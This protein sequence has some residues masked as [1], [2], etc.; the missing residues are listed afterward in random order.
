MKLSDY[1]W[2]FIEQKVAD[3][4]F[5][6]S[7]GGI[8][9][10]VD[11]LGRSNLKSYCCHHEQAVAIAAEGY[12]RI[13]NSP[14]VAL[15]T[16]GPGGTNAVTG[17]AGAWLDSI[18]M[19]VVAGQVKRAD[20]TPRDANG[21]PVVRAIGF[22]E[23]NVIDIAKPVCKYAVTVENEN[24]I[25][26]HLEK[27]LYLATHGRPG[28]VFV[29]IPLDVQAAE[30]DP[31]TL[32]SFQPESWNPG[33][34]ERATME[35]IVTLLREAKRPL[36]IAGNGIRLAGGEEIL[37]KSLDKFKI[38]AVTPIFTA[39]DL[40]TYDYPYYLGRQGMPGNKAANYAA[41]NCDLLLIVGERMQLTQV[42]WDYNKFAPNAKKIMVDIDDNE[43]K[44][45]QLSVDLAVHCDAK[46]FLDELYKQDITL[47]RWDVKVEPLNPADLACDPKY[48]NVYKFWREIGACNMSFRPGSRNP[49]L[50]ITTANGMASLTPHQALKVSRGQRFLTNAGLGHMGSGLPM[51]IGASI[52]RGRQAVICSEGDGSIMMNLQELQTVVHHK[53]P[54]KIF[55]VNNNGYYSIRATHTHFFKKIFASD[56][57]TGVSIP[58]FS[59]LIPAW[60]IA[61]ERINND[62]E[63]DKVKKV[64]DFDGPIVCELMIDPDQKMPEKWSAGLYAEIPYVNSSSA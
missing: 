64:M 61:F 56:P 50:D 39:D 58:D 7:G 20:I 26:Y 18:P 44:R 28:P 2:Q 6:V 51:A 30:I 27:A 24:E 34:L 10:L 29:E 46:V 32:L 16:T 12:G 14:G 37:W 8:M 52:A 47:N 42:S 9:H 60:G 25:R 3:S 19:F 53:L 22:Q 62:S 21:Q 48:L 4:V 15:V 63:L 11:S 5:L 41:D 13:K 33:S 59:K 36:L 35:K 55:I 23:L 17:M 45:K 40:V 43:M 1:V 49:G 57:E 38:N 31:D 54:L